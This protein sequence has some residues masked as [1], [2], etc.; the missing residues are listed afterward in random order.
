MSQE[1]KDFLHNKGIATSRT[2]SYNPAG[3]GQVERLNGTI[4]QAITFA[5]KL[6]NCLSFA[7]KTFYPMHSILFEPIV[8]HCNE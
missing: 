4:W 5:L 3:N 6:I 7:G 2:T 8:I 1:L